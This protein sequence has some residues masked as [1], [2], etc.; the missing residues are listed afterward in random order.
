MTHLVHDVVG[1]MA[2]HG[3][4]PGIVGDKFNGSGCAHRNE[5]RG[6]RPAGRF[7]NQ[8]AI[9]H[10]FFKGVAVKVDRVMVHGGQIADA[11]PDALACL[12]DKRRGAGKGSG[13]E[14]QDIKIRRFI[15]V[16]AAGPRAQFPG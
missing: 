16:G 11:D 6:F 8:A 3:P 10:D 4:V 9:G 7:R 14:G 12:R 5:C 1:H 2:M 13:I 15:G